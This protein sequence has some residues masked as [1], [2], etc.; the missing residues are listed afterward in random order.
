MTVVLDLFE[1]HLLVTLVSFRLQGGLNRTNMVRAR[2][3][4]W[5]SGFYVE[6]FLDVDEL[7]M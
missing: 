7:K 3:S 6:I 1:A 4:V 2:G 5:Q